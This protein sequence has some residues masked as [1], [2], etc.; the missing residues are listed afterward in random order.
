MEDSSTAFRPSLIAFIVDSASRSVSSLS[1]RAKSERYR[2]EKSIFAN[3]LSRWWE[4]IL[5][6]HHRGV[7]G[8]QLHTYVLGPVLGMVWWFQ[9][10]WFGCLVALLLC[11]SCTWPLGS[12]SLPSGAC[13]TPKQFTIL[14]THVCIYTQTQIIKPLSLSSS[15]TESWQRRHWWSSCPS[16]T[17]SSASLSQSSVRLVDLHRDTITHSVQYISNTSILHCI[18]MY[19]LPE[20]V[21]SVLSRP[22]PKPS[23]G[24]TALRGLLGGFI[25]KRRE[26]CVSAPVSVWLGPAEPIVKVG[27]CDW[28][29]GAIQ[30]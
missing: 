1:T 20:S 15:S 24:R 30:L 10:V 27:S 29:E 4:I 12:P 5:Q 23:P 17:S 2:E 25:L 26:D 9:N 6:K 28:M 7:Q 19:L 3:V 8:Y 21:S 16:K 13:G 14:T 18:Y 11:T 22:F